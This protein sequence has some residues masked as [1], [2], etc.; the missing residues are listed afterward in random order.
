MPCLILLL[1]IAFPRLV[2]LAL[3]FFTNYLSAA[4]TGLL[5][6]VVGFLFLPITTIT[7]AWLVNS[8]VPIEGFNVL[9]LILAVIL[10]MGSWGGGEYSRRRH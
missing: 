3:F 9:Y 5:V 8:Q 10:D 7:Y 1:V 6:P 2:L 4:Y